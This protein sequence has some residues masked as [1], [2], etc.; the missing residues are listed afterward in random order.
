MNHTP[1]IRKAIQ[2]AAKKHHG[3]VRV[4]KEE[5]PYVTHLFSVALLLAEDEGDDEVVIAGLLHDTIEDTGTREDEI[6]LAFGARVASIVATVTEPKEE[7]GKPLEWKERKK[8]YLTQL[9]LGS[10]EAL[11]VSVADKID[12][13]ESKLESFKHEGPE[14]L[15]AWSQPAESY[16]WYHGAVLNMAKERLPKHPLTKRLAEAHQREQ[17]TFL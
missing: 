4:G 5:L 6:A 7:V 16:I 17:E 12:N 13:I 2:F 10:D 14:F 9:E 15:G 8:R 3:Q 11:L 1:E